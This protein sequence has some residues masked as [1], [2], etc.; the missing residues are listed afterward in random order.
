V[1]YAVTD[2]EQPSVCPACFFPLPAATVDAC[3]ECR[4]PLTPSSTFDHLAII[5]AQGEMFRRGANNP[6]GL[7]VVG[8]WLLFGPTSVVF[9]LL[10]FS[11]GPLGL[12]TSVPIL[13]LYA[14]ILWKVTSRY[15][16]ARRE[17]SKETVELR[18]DEPEHDRWDA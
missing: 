6:S 3:P 10:A 4:A 9:V 11:N 18:Y 13:L 7:V 8:M 1:R 16:A 17:Q 12:V 15:R 2:T 5:S 14:A